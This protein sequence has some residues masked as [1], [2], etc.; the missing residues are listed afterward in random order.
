[1]ALVCWN[2]TRPPSEFDRDPPEPKCAECN[3]VEVEDAGMICLE[4][5]AEMEAEREEAIRDREADR[6]VNEMRE[7][8]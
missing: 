7:D 1:M 8:V 3:E 6:D 5:A 4:C 2:Q